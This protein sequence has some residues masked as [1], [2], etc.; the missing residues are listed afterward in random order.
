MNLAH[1]VVKAKEIWHPLTSTGTCT[2]IGLFA[3]AQRIS[4]FIWKNVKQNM[5]YCSYG[6]KQA[7]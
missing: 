5:V 1:P 7:Y 4:D 6:R 3:L 2:L